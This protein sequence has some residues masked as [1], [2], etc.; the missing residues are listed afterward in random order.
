MGGGVIIFDVFYLNYKENINLINF[1]L[2][3]LKIIGYVKGER[4]KYI[5]DLFF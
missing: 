4:I 5:I 3:C 1:N 2:D